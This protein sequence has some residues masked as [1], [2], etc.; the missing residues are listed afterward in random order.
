MPPLNRIMPSRVTNQ[1]FVI[2]NDENRYG[3]PNHVIQYP[4]TLASSTAFEFFLD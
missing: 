3:H 2:F 4:C 1:L